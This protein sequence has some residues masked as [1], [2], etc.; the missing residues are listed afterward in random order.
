MSKEKTNQSSEQVT[1]L[2]ERLVSIVA[3]NADARTD[4]STSAE[5]IMNEDAQMWDLVRQYAPEYSEYEQE[6]VDEQSVST[7]PK[8]LEL[9]RENSAL[10][11]E[12]QRLQE[13]EE[14]TSQ[15]LQMFVTTLVGLQNDIQQH[16]QK[17]SKSKA[18]LINS[19]E[20]RVAEEQRAYQEYKRDY[21]KM[22]QALKIL[23]IK[24]NKVKSNMDHDIAELGSTQPN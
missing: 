4:V 1:R 6:Y 13:V 21:V 19:Y 10:R 22:L 7:D 12:L 23:N 20:R 16:E 14:R 3:S 24:L 5:A 15:T 11:M 18:S 8:Q 9:I 17:Y 2:V